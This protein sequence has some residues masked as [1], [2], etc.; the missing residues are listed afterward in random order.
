MRHAPTVC[1]YLI[2]DNCLFKKIYSSFVPRT[3]DTVRIGG[4]GSEKYYRAGEVVWV[5]DEPEYPYDR[6][7]VGVVMIEDNS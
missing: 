1:I 6:V 2:L 7:N 4:E 5:Y 3:G